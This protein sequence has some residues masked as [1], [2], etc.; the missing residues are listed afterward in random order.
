M[1]NNVL[2]LQ[3]KRR[4]GGN[5]VTQR[6]FLD[7]VIDGEPLSEMLRGDFVSCFAWSDQENAKAVD[8]LL[9]NEEADFPNDRHSLYVCPECG[10]LGCGAVSAVIEERDNK[11]IWR[12]FGYQNN[13]EDEVRSDLLTGNYSFA[14]DKSDYEKVIK[15]ALSV[16]LENDRL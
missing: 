6:D 11:I 15:G 5:G 3:R 8:R 7:F 2:S 14:F 13:Y 10:D 1:G 4:E 9:L 16:S 12:D